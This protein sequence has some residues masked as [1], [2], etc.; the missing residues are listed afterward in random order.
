AR[1]K[2]APAAAERQSPSN[3]PGSNSSPGTVGCTAIWKGTNG[4]AGRRAKL[5]PPSWDTQTPPLSSKVSL[6]MNNVCG[7]PGGMRRMNA[8]SSCSA[9]T[10]GSSTKVRPPSVDLKSAP[11]N[12]SRV[13]GQNVRGL[14]IQRI[15][16]AIG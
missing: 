10:A 11:T 6:A 3:D 12:V 5:A 16:R 15:D 14:R 2:G 13:L 9:E 1:G 4:A 7:R 8:P